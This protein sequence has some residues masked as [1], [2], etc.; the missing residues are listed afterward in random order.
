MPKA[1]E[2]IQQ[3]PGWPDD[4]GG[5]ENAEQARILSSLLASKPA[6]V[7]AMAG[8]LEG[9][10]ASA[11]QGTGV[12]TFLPAHCGAL[13]ELFVQVAR[14]HAPTD[15]ELEHLAR[16]LPRAGGPQPMTTLVRGI[17]A[18]TG[19]LRD[20]IEAEAG[21]AP[22]GRSALYA[23]G[24]SLSRLTDALLDHLI[25][26]TFRREAEEGAQGRRQLLETMLLGRYTL[27]D[28][29]RARAAGAGIDPA[30]R[31]LVIVAT[32]ETRRTNV[33][34]EHIVRY[35]VEGLVAGLR[36]Q[37]RNPFAVAR[38]SEVVAIVPAPS[39]TSELR[40]GLEG[41]VQ[42]MGG[43]LAMRTAIGISAPCAGLIEV[44]VGYDEASRMLRRV[45]AAGGVVSASEI[46]LID[47]LV[48]QTGSAA[49]RIVSS[50]ARVLVQEDGRW[51]G[52]LVGTLSAYLDND[53]SVERTA[54]ALSVHANTVYYRLGRITRL[55]GVQARN[56]WALV[57]LL[58]GVQ[59]LRTAEA[60]QPGREAPRL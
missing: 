17:R 3:P 44:P 23:V 48:L 37:T 15:E 32:A 14:G 47:Y 10:L 35:L 33:P 38:G 6:L 46:S 40:K 18:E 53:L 22:E 24:S 27:S 4:P 49:R 51:D 5:P 42:R 58:A 59:I 2:K 31:L 29:I 52:A 36:R 26:A 56:V 11:D 9:E 19:V 60:A 7:I 39:S 12:G 1:R 50:E 25:D 57:D 30:V 41:V 13:V 21:Q 55:T 16:I 34:P 28:Q 20:R 54:S 8:A 45:V 43:K